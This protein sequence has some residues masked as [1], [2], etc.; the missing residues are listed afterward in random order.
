VPEEL[1]EVYAALPQNEKASIKEFL[2]RTSTGKNVKAEFKKT[3]ENMISGK[4]NS[5]KNKY[6]DLERNSVFLPELSEAGII[7]A[8]V[9]KKIEQENGLF[10]RNI[11]EIKDEE[12]P[13]AVNLIKLV[14]EKLKRRMTRK[15]KITSRKS[16]LDFKRTIRNSLSTGGVPFRLKYKRHPRRKEKL[17]LLCDVSASMYRFS[18]FVLQFVLGIQT[19]FRS[20]DTYIFSEE[21][22]HLHVN[23][24]MNVQGFEQ[25]VRES[26]VWRKGTNINNAFIHL[27]SDWYTILNS[28]TV[29]II[30]SDAKT[31][32][33]GKALENLKILKSKVKNVLWLNPLPEKEW[34]KDRNICE[35][36]KYCTMLDC[37]TLERL[38]KACAAL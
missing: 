1:K 4:L 13:A 14:V 30:V 31:L 6:Q 18:G 23:R 5:L 28:S 11:S 24:F 34:K 16:R 15:Y 19:S 9:K 20:V 29:A 37:S 8:E 2:E 38:A 35:F 36:E 10:F 7:A 3:V 21:L 25:M 22:M 32:D 33:A 17:V 26:P 12:I 27:L